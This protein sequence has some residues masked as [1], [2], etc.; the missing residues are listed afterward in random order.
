MLNGITWKGERAKIVLIEKM[1]VEQLKIAENRE[2][3]WLVYSA[4]RFPSIK[5][6]ILYKLDKEMRGVLKG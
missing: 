5:S 2:N 6:M 4:D 3:R 1:K